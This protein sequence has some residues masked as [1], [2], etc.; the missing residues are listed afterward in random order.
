MAKG[1]EIVLTGAPMGR[2]LEGTITGTP[3][4]GTL[5]QVD[6]SEGLDGNG[7]CTYEVYTPGVD[8]NRR[9]I[10]VLLP[11]KLRG[12]TELDAYATGDHGFLYVPCPGDELNILYQS[13]AG[14]VTF[15]DLLIADNST[16]LVIPTAGTPE[17]EPFQAL[18]T[19]TTPAADLLIHVFHTGY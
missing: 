4:P 11:D 3:K 18:E 15:G 12:K 14:T 7:R 6:V 1:N 8:G 16:G 9:M 5:M 2:Y 10:A 13:A 17:S 19:Q